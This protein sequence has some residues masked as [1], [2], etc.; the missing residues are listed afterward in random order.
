MGEQVYRIGDLRDRVLA[1]L[2]Q[3]RGA[4]SAGTICQ[5]LN[6]PYWAVKAGIELAQ[7][8]GLA[9]YVPGDGYRAADEVRHEQ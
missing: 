3:E 1:L 9:V 6:M 4:V 7:T 8:D 2:R 5:R